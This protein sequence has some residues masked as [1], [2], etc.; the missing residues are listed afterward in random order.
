MRHRPKSCYGPDAARARHAVGCR[1]ARPLCRFMR[2][3]QKAKY[4]VC[5]CGA[6]HF[7]HRRGSGQCGNPYAPLVSLAEYRKMRG[8]AE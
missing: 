6:Y 3:A 4:G 2:Q 5:G 1:P 8:A 7:P